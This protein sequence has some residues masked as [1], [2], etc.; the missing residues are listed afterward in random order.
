MFKTL[1]GAFELLSFTPT[2]LLRA[3]TPRWLPEESIP[4]AYGGSGIPLG[5]APAEIMRR[6]YATEGSR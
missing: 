1:L 2:G 6:R 4:V 3:K 5:T